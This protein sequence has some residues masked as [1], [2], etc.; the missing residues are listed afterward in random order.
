MVLQLAE[1]VLM[2][3]GIAIV[4]EDDVLDEDFEL[5][6]F[7]LFLHC[8]IVEELVFFFDQFDGIFVQNFSVVNVME[9]DSVHPRI[10]I[11]IVVET[12]PDVEELFQGFERGVANHDGVEQFF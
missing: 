3:Q 6:L 10:W 9:A 12:D 5:L 1:Q 8:G 4:S 7:Y 2:F 11:F